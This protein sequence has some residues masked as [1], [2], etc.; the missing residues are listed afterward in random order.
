CLARY[1][2]SLTA[3]V[4]IL[5]RAERLQLS[6]Q[7]TALREHAASLPHPALEA[8]AREHADYLAHLADGYDLL[9]RQVLLVLRAPAHPGH[10]HP[11]AAGGPAR[12]RWTRRTTRAQAGQVP[13]RVAEVREVCLGK[14]TRW[15]CKYPATGAIRDLG[16]VAGGTQLWLGERR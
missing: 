16:V 7:I 5:I 3:P 13:R 10:T 6:E 8:A 11:T 14:C 12:N 4:Q 15:G 9:R 2:L 1:L